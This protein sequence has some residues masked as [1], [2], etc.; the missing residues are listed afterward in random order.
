MLI[1][2]IFRNIDQLGAQSFGNS[3][4]ELFYIIQ[5]DF[6][7]LSKFNLQTNHTVRYLFGS[8]AKAISQFIHAILQKYEICMQLLNEHS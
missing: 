3:I 6:L 7:Y 5:I 8:D 2:G 1:P 4:D